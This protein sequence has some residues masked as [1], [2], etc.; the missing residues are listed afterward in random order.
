M[1]ANA[2][3]NRLRTRRGGEE[4]ALP[5]AN[6]MYTMYAVLGG[7]LFLVVAGGLIYRLF[8][9]CF[10]RAR[11]V[12]ARL[13]DKEESS[14]ERVGTSGKVYRKAD[15]ILVFEAGGRQLRFLTSFWNYDAFKVGTH[16]VLKY[17]GG[18]FLSFTPNR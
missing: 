14:Y 9:D 18:K 4:F 2:A 8:R 16:G 7:A 6:I 3:E 12:Q 1:E 11:T 15:Y 5:E 13:A 10:S 17:R